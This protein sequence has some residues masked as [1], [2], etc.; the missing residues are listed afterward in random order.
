[1]ADLSQTPANVTTG[2]RTAVISQVQYGET[3]SAGMPVY[4][5][6]STLKYLKCDAD[7]SLAA[8]VARGI[9]QEGGILDDYKLI[10]TGGPI[11]VGA[12]LTQGE[13]YYVSDTAGGIK[14]H[15]DLGTGDYITLLG[16][17]IS[18]SVLDM[19]IKAYQVAKT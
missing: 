4:Q 9:A 5:D 7:A 2:G 12:T 17:A 8:S 3:I 18:T 13:A 14:P 15:A 1:M 6:A 16:H 11:N 19:A 10:Q